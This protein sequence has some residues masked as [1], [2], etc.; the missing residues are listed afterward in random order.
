V[1][2]PQA[3]PV[4]DLRAAFAKLGKQEASDDAMA[5]ELC[6]GSVKIVENLKPNFKI[7]TVEDLQLAGSLLK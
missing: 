2:T 7:T 1:Q 5:V 6:G 4:K 3:F